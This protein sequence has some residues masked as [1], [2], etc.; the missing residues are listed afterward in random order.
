M[1]KS[2][3]KA[4]VLSVVSL[5]VCV[6]MLLGST[7]AWFTDSVSV[8]N[9]EIVAGNLDIELYHTNRV[10]TEEKV[11]EDTPLFD[12]VTLWEPGAVAYENLKIV[13]EGTLSL[14]YLL[15][16]NFTD[17]NTVDGKS[18][19]DILKI[20][21]V[22]DAAV[23]TEGS[24][25]EQ[26]AAAVEL[27]KTTGFELINSFDY[28]NVLEAEGEEKQLALIIWW[29]PSSDDN[30]FNVN[31]D[32]TTSDGEPLDINL[33]LKLF[34]TQHTLELDSFD[35]NYDKDAGLDFYP[36]ST[37]EE[38]IAALDNGEEN[39]QLTDNIYI[40]ETVNVLNDTTLKG[41]GFDFMREP[42]VS[43]FAVEGETTGF[44][45]TMFSVKNGTELVLKDVVLD[46]GAVWSGEID[47]T[48][49]RSL[50]NTGA[51]ATGN[52][53]AVEAG[54]VL[55]LE[56]GALLQNNDGISA[57]NVAGTLN[58]NGGEIINNTANGGGAIWGAGTIVINDGKINGNYSISI[59]GAVRMTTGK[60]L[61][62]NGGEM[63]HNKAVTTG[64][65]IYGYSKEVVELLGGEMAYNEASA[66]GAIWTGGTAA[67]MSA[68]Y[69]ISGTHKMHDNKAL[70][71]GG[72][73][74]V[75]RYTTLNM[76]GGEVYN[77]FSEGGANAFYFYDN[78]VY[79]LGGTIRDNE[80]GGNYAISYS[81]GYTLTLGNANVED[82]LYLNVG[83]NHRTVALAKEFGEYN[84]V[85]SAPETDWDVYNFNAAED[86]VYTE[87]DED[88][89][90]YETGEYKAVWDEVN[91][92]F[93]L[94]P[95]A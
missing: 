47:S 66:G 55:T 27:G 46:G 9:N 85:I 87:G 75:T 40:S 43:T 48:L 61:T 92:K 32:K 31:N 25:E 95:N 41:N 5:L 13:N 18:L 33:G 8:L 54:A 45:G 58:V 77:N 59:G 91:T 53:V 69:T 52:L 42:G 19:K 16:I 88:K 37:Y 51:T 39:I 82:T 68:N 90:V 24:E 44:T 4:L 49:Q 63:N 36:V 14:E 83:T 22:E 12:D 11:E 17:Y 64:G 15:S 21:L 26:R 29:E 94:E 78:N 35:E 73:I 20:A 93:V 30:D 67:S 60:K 3:K 10:D 79:L 89:L 7:F 28:K 50:T 6:S 76:T 81:G 80:A 62:M 34:A 72:A 74:R 56:K 84:F 1:S 65:A 70:E 23:S 57:V 71:L 86:Y 2:N 38:L